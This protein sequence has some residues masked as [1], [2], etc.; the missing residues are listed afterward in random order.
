MVRDVGVV[1]VDA[2]LETLERCFAEARVS[3]LPV[4][5]KGTVVG[6]VSRADVL[7]ALGGPGS[8]LP[9][10]SLFY[11]DLAAFE[12]EE[13]LE[14]FADA[15]ERGA[16]RLQ[17]LRVRDLLTRSIVAVEPE[18]PIREVA[19][20]LAEHRVHRALVID[21]G[22]LVGIISALDIVGLVAEGGIATG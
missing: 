8:S 10:L 21:E 7:R 12:A 11:A 19:R 6:V 18:D 15:A 22:T 2:D 4:V 3:G 13:V 16:R 20:T 14:R 1:D 9:R 17:D 5:E